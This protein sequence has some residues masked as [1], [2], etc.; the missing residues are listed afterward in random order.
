MALPFLHRSKVSDHDTAAAR[1]RL[2]AIAI[3]RSGPP[4]RVDAGTVAQPPPH[5]VARP[6]AQPVAQPV[7]RRAVRPVDQPAARPAVRSA[8]QPAED[9]R[10][11]LTDAPPWPTSPDP[12]A[13]AGD[14]ARPEPS[15]E[16]GDARP[17]EAEPSARRARRRHHCARRS[18]LD[19]VRDL[20]PPA[21]RSGRLAVDGTAAVSVAVVVLLAALLG[22]A[23]LWKARPTGAALPPPALTEP[24]PS[25]APGAQAGTGVPTGGGAVIVDV[26]GLVRRPGVVRLPVGSRVQD[27]LRAAGGAVPGAGTASLNL[28][29]VLTDGEQV[30]VTKPGVVPPAGDG[31]AAPGAGGGAAGG[32]AGGP[33]GSAV[34]DLNTATLDQ[35]D[36]LPGVGPV[37]AQRILD[38]RTEHGRFSSVEELREVNGIGD[39]RFAD[40]K[41]RVRV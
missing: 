5:L 25:A 9:S 3:A 10:V 34:V 17:P 12:A 20:L 19:L 2:K 29:R 22:G 24:S 7:A 27:A 35:L 15:P 37:L 23:Y 14:P 21:V 4:G 41:G 36:A 28:A 13:D 39:R 1:E 11:L 8:A 33:A 18:P 6:A 26:Q 30:V 38:W 16:V 40:L 32:P 31:A